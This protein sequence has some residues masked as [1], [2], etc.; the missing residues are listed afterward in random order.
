MDPALTDGLT[1]DSLLQPSRLFIN[2]TT[3]LDWFETSPGTTQG[4]ITLR[5][6]QKYHLRWDRLQAA[7]ASGSGPGLRWQPP[8]ATPQL[9]PIPTGR[10]YALAPPRGSGS[11]LKASYF[12]N[13][14]GPHRSEVE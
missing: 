12:D 9:G 11:G 7:P 8:T 13:W 4:S 10:L 3:V 1:F 5:A 14:T 6:G 2:G